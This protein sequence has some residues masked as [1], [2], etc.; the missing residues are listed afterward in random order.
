MLRFITVPKTPQAN[1]LFTEFT[2]NDALLEA[3]RFSLTNSRITLQAHNNRR[4]AAFI[5]F[6]DNW[7]VAIWPGKIFDTE[8]QAALGRMFSD[9]RQMLG[10]HLLRTVIGE[11]EEVTMSALLACGW[12]HDGVYRKLSRNQDGSYIDGIIL[13]FDDTH[14]VSQASPQ[15]APQEPSAG[16]AKEEDDNGKFSRPREDEEQ[17]NGE[18]LAAEPSPVL[19]P[20]E[21][22][23]GEHAEPG[24]EPALLW[25]V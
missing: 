24:A 4:T 20:G 13:S 2:D 7:N 25:F 10:Y 5:S 12:Q 3:L 16:E 6:Y 1:I 15:T 9:M 19:D 8:E 17:I 18:P 21:V 22:H 23:V 14:A 11:N